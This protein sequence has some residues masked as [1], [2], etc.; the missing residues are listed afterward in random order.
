[1]EYFNRLLVLRIPADCDS[2]GVR[3]GRRPKRGHWPIIS[4]T[5]SDLNRPS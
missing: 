4:A 5:T 2:Q 1:V 3:E